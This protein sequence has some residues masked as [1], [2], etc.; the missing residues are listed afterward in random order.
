M[1]EVAK[2]PERM[3]VG[4]WIREL[5]W[6]EHIG[7]RSR[8]WRRSGKGLKGSHG[9]L[10]GGSRTSACCKSLNDFKDVFIVVREFQ[11]GSSRMN[12]GQRGSEN[13]V[14]VGTLL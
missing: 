6:R 1:L 2:S 5:G 8:A 11:N 10:V 3:R 14:L 7:S 12:L 13:G 9:D 4:T